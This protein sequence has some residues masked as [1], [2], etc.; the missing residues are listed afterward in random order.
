MDSNN[1][2]QQPQQSYQQPYQ[3]PQQPYQ[4]PYQQPQ[5]TYRQ[6]ASEKPVGLGEWLGT[7]FLTCIPCVGVILLFVWA[8]SKDTSQSKS[9]W[10]KAQLIFSLIILVITILIYVVLFA[11]MGL[12]LQDMF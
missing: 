11:V 3:Q 5:Q 4:Q 9:N 2:N 12:A 7:L 6:P 1:L 10:A 8:F